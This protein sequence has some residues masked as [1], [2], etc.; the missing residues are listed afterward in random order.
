MRIYYFF[1]SLAWS[2]IGKKI[3]TIEKAIKMGL[4]HQTNIYGDGIIMTGYCRSFW[5]DKYGNTYGCSQLL[6]GGRDFVMDKIKEE[7]PELF[8]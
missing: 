3:P 2:I 6:D 7:H 4:T 1:K 8:I 5:L